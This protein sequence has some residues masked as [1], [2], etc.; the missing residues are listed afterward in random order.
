VHAQFI[1]DGGNDRIKEMFKQ[2]RL[3]AEAFAQRTANWGAKSARL[4][5]IA[6]LLRKTVE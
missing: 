3:G 1:I 4:R 5:T 6:Y 2:L